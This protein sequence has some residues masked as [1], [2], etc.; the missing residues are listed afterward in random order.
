MQ[1]VNQEY[2]KLCNTDVVYTDDKKSLACS[3][4]ICGNGT[5]TLKDVDAPNNNITL[6]DEVYCDYCGYRD[7]AYFYF[8]HYHAKAF[9]AYLKD[10]EYLW[11]MVNDDL[12]SSWLK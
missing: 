12:Y 11:I 8:K 6:Y 5:L 2:F 4:H 3:C 9:S 10:L 7:K 1:F